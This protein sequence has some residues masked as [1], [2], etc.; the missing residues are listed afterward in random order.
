MTT[1]ETA[2][3]FCALLKAGQHEEAA[4]RFNADDIVS[5][6]D[7]EGPMA[8]LEGKAAVKGKSDWWYANHEVHEAKSSGPFVHGD[9][10]CVIFELD[11]TPKQTGQRMQMKEIGLYTLRDGKIAE[12]R[13]FY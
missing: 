12:E 2:E 1:R 4:A 13:F 6:E 10:F 5:L 11:V 8:R 9:Q 3:A 7:M